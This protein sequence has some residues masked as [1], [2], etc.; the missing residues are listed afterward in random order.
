LERPW[1]FIEGATV[2]RREKPNEPITP[3][4]WFITFKCRNVGRSPLVVDECI[5]KLQDRDTLPP[6]PNYDGANPHGTQRWASPNEAFET[7]PPFGPA[8]E[9]AMKDGRPIEFIVYGRITYSELN[10]TK[11]Q[12]GFAVAVSAYMAAF[13]GYPNDAYDYYN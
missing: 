8:P 10:G 9:T 4:N 3:N 13:T 6:R 1:L 5:V 2:S 7:E 12:T 11:H